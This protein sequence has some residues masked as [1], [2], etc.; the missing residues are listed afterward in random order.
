VKYR[1]KNTEKSV[2]VLSGGK[3]WGATLSSWAMWLFIAVYAAETAANIFLLS[4]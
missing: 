2:P 1:N 4:C 3:L